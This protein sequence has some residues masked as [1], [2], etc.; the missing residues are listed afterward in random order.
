MI[1]YNGAVNGEDPLHKFH[2]EDFYV[3]DNVVVYLGHSEIPKIKDTSKIHILIELEQPNRFAFLDSRNTTFECENYYD[4]ILTINSEFVNNRNTKLDKKLYK[5]VF[6]P[7]STK[8]LTNFGFHNKPYDVIY[9]G[10]KTYGLNYIDEAKKH[11]FAFVSNWGKS[12]VTHM[13]VSYN[14]KINLIGQSKISLSH[15]IVELNEKNEQSDYLKELKKN[16]SVSN[17]TIQQ[18]KA[19]TI[20]AAFNKSII[21]HYKFENNVIEDLF[22]EGVDFLYYRPGIIDEIITNYKNYQFLAENAYNKAIQNYS[23]THFYEK[24]LKPIWENN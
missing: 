18:Y 17:G 24:H 11:K 3:P 2:F 1:Q 21:I 16:V 6:F 14:D 13:G 8:Y 4:H 7:Y 5:T 9:T 15:S 23:T 22:K 10:H 19:R 20:E 12:D